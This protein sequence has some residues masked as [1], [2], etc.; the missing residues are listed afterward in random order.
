MEKRLT[1]SDY[2]FSLII[3]FL[4]VCIAGAF[5]YGMEVGKTRTETKFA[6]V[7]AKQEEMAKKPGAYEQQHLVSFYHTVWLPYREFQNKWFHQLKE[8]DINTQT[9][10]ASAIMKELSLTAGDKMDAVSR[11]SMPDTSP[12]LREAQQN[13]MKSLKLFGDTLKKYQAKANSMH[14]SVLLA[15]LDKDPLLSDAKKY[16][17]QAQQQYYTAMTKWNQT[18]SLDV[19]GIDLIG[20]NPVTLKDWSQMSLVVKND[21]VA[22]L[23]LNGMHFTSIYPQD[24]TLRVEEMIGSGQAKKMNLNEISAIVEMLLSTNAVREGDFIQRKTKFYAEETLPQ[25]PFFYQ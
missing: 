8:M 11:A 4:L 17:L 5:F 19:K 10:D 18:V 22:G 24:L 3:V 20:R 16:A 14:P 21:V 2:I 7:M 25:L 23:L 6:A 15:E 12:L 9:V 13:Y 1:R